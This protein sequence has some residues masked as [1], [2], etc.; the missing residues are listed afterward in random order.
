MSRKLKKYRTAC[1]FPRT[2]FFTGFGS[3]FSITGGYYS[4]NYSKSSEEIDAK[5]LENDWGVIGQ[6]M[7]KAMK[8]IQ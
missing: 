2:D 5:A 6:D 3:I 8:K 7:K 4:S 1:L